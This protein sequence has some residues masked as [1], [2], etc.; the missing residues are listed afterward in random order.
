MGGNRLVKRN[1]APEIPEQ[2]R[3]LGGSGRGGCAPPGVAAPPK[4]LCVVFIVTVGVPPSV[5]RAAIT[6]RIS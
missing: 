5:W 4:Y 1:G 3:A 6:Q 2:L